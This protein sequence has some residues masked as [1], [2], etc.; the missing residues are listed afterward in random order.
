[1]EALVDSGDR[2]VGIVYFEKRRPVMEGEMCN[3]SLVMLVAIAT[4]NQ[5]VGMKQVDGFRYENSDSFERLN[6]P[7]VKEQNGVC[8]RLGVG[9]VRKSAWQEEPRKMAGVVLLG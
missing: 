9:Q 1:M 2:W 5:P 3:F 4:V 7:A 6:V 8:E